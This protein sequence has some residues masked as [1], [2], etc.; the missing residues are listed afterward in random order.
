MTPT[1][2]PALLCVDDEPLVLEGLTLH[3]RRAFTLTTATSGAAGLEVL[4]GKGTFAIVMSDMRMPSMNGA[5]FLAKV[6]EGWPDTVR[7]LLTGQSDLPSAIAAVNDG[8]IFRFLTKPCPPDVLLG[9]L[10]AASKQYD[11][12]SGERVLLEQT[13]H[14][15]IKALT[16]VLSLANPVAFG[17]ANRAKQFMGQLLAETQRPSDWICDVAAMLSQIGCVTIPAETLDRMYDGSQLSPEEMA[18]AARIPAVAVQLLGPIPRL[19]GV[20]DILT[21][22]DDHYEPTKAGQTKRGE[23]IP[24]GARALKIILDYLTLEARLSDGAEALETMRARKGWYDPALVP[25]FAE[26]AARSASNEVRQLVV[27]DLRQG[28]ILRE[29]VFT[30][31]GMLL[32]TKGNEVTAGL[33]ERIA[34]FSRKVGVREPISVSIPSGPAKSG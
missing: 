13:L 16:D 10:G 7:V 19:E 31:P 28:M 5:E 20:R 6:R 4:K 18:M 22:M 32:V 8:Q 12:L 26:V 30:K 14:G 33:L 17:R 21:H 27:R 25:P 15:S 2:K 34:N 24:W 1:A 11:L 3:L 29:N 9:A 23:A